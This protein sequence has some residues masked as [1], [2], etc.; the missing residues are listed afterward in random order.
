MHRSQLKLSH[1]VGSITF[2]PP[3][4]QCDTVAGWFSTDRRVIITPS[5]GI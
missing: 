1:Q 5:P 2:P 3:V 4:L